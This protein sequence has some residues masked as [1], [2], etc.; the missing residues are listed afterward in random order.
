MFALLSFSTTAFRPPPD[1]PDCAIALPR[2]MLVL[3]PF[4]SYALFV[5]A[6][7]RQRLDLR[8]S[9]L[10]A[11]IPWTVFI[12]LIT[13][14]L[15]ATHA[16]TRAG[17]AIAWLV[18]TLACGAWLVF[19]KPAQPTAPA[20]DK[21]AAP[22]FDLPDRLALALTGLLVALVGLTAI[23]CAPNTWDAMQYHLPRV[24]EWI[25][26]RGVQLYPTID[27]GQLSMPPL[28]EY[29][30]LHLD[31]LYGSDRLVNLVQWFAY[32][33]C[34]LGV[35]V[36]VEELGGNRRAQ[37]L[38]A[39][40]TAA[41]PTAVLG[42]SS[43]KN[44][45]VLAYWITLAVYFLLRW[46][47]RQDWPNTLAIA[48]TLSLAIFT[49]GTAYVFVPSLVV[50]CALT[51]N[52]EAVRRFAI[53]LPVFIL[54]CVVV[55]G[56]LWARNHAFSGSI[57]GLP[58]FDGQGSVQGRMFANSHIT[59]ARTL[60][61]VARYTALNVST[62]SS[63]LNDLLTRA[64]SGFIRAIGV[65]PNDSTQIFCSQN[66]NCPP[67]TVHFE[68]K[69]EYYCG[70]QIQLF[71]FVVAAA[72][73]IANFRKMRSATGWLAL[74]LAGAFV[75]QAAMLRWSPWSARYQLTLFVLAGVFIALVLVQTL[76][77]RL[78]A[79]ALLLPLI[80]ALPIALMNESRPLM[81][82]HRPKLSILTM[83][84][85][86]TYFLNRREDL[87][88]SF[89][90]ASRAT[91]S[92][93]CRAVGIDAKLLH[94]EYPIFAL[95][96][97]DKKPRFFSYV[98]VDN[99]TEKF[100]SAQT[101]APCAVVCLGCASAPQKWQQYQSQGFLGSTFADVVVFHEPNDTPRDESAAGQ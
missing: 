101:P 80:F 33:G 57:L 48:S 12:A 76:P 84:R 67:F 11:S 68:P 72:L 93:S 42:A 19:T 16:L 44:D 6:F 5:E 62:P 52:R 66:G 46:R 73:Y 96:S 7:R 85:D 82:R 18:F 40:L 81:E 55:N 34:I 20:N 77:R 51:W 27:R 3:L 94:F 64:F 49:K 43:T 1:Y 65:D 15:S 10:I 2:S 24:V 14:A 38:A 8:R 75:M 36:I 87:A 53:R 100:R 71:L 13:E 28:A 91:R 4:L 29:I 74:G 39:A 89:I 25:S 99:P 9:L 41:L 69:Y 59:P 54:L 79:L 98:S 95:I 70:N 56:P 61:S 47:V 23:V 63:H 83:P 32:V 22:R 58:Y 30:V 50:A 60:A 78:Q 37:V 35:S 88:A 92:L 31:L 97:E 86:E 21:A 45:Q 17:A 90:A 26:N